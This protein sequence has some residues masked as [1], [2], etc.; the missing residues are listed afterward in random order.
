MD[1]SGV[2]GVVCVCA[3]V[4]VCVCVSLKKIQ[5]VAFFVYTLYII[6]RKE[7]HLKDV[8]FDKHIKCK[9]KFHQVQ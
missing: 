3:C 6:T 2:G 8:R 4:C 5:N 9:V 1:E 7:K